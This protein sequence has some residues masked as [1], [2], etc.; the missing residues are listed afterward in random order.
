[1]DDEDYDL[2]VTIGF[3]LFSYALLKHPIPVDIFIER[4]HLCHKDT[5]RSIPGVSCTPRKK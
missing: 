4:K 3:L 5:A 2:S 1:M